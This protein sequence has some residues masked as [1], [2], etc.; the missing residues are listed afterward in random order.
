M[1]MEGH[2]DRSM[3]NNSFEK[4]AQHRETCHS[5]YFLLYK[6]K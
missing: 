5:I 4:F 6:T 3:F 2:Q 1:D